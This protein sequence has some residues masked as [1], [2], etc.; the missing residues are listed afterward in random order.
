[1]QHKN[2]DLQLGSLHQAMLNDIKEE[3]LRKEVTTIDLLGNPVPHAGVIINSNHLDT[4]VYVEVECVIL[5][6]GRLFFSSVDDGYED[7]L[8][9]LDRDVMEGSLISVYEAVCDFFNYLDYEQIKAA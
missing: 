5:K 2:Y 8:M 4:P 1:M 3:M 7:E 9:P 6:D